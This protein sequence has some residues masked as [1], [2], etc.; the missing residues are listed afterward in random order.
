MNSKGSNFN[1][2]AIRFQ[3]YTKEDFGQSKSV[4][5]RFCTNSFSKLS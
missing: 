3:L 1:H 2:K 4:F 5:H